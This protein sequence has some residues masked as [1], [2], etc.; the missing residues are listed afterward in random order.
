MSR[1]LLHLSERQFEASLLPERRGQQWNEA[2][3]IDARS[4]WPL[5][6]NGRCGDV[7]QIDLQCMTWVSDEKMDGKG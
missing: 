2:G 3:R 7:A 5:V 1:V 6:S 4:S